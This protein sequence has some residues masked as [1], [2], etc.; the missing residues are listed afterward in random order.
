MITYNELAKSVEFSSTKRG[1]VLERKSNDLE[2]IGAGRSAYVF[3]IKSTNKALKVFFPEFSHIA[4]EEAEIYQL[5]Q[6]ISYFPTMYDA[7]DN[8]LVID[9]IE[10]HTLFECL[11]KGIEIKPD[12]INK[13]DEALK[14]AKDQGLNPSDI[15]LRNLIITPEEQIKIIDVARFRQTKNCTQWD[16]LKRAFYKFYC[17]PLFPKKIPVFILN[18]IAALYK[19]EILINLVRR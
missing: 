10:G 14:R 3:K 19:K 9:L 17:K 18:S 16:D 11:S 1:I 12:K 8:Y 13:I 5:L 2:F 4:G 6:G 7:G 15:H